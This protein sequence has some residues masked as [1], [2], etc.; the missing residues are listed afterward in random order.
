M[1]ST[2][3]NTYSTQIATTAYVQTELTDLI[4]GA[5]GTLDTLNE[6]AA[7]INDD[8]SYASTLTTALAT[9]LNLA[10][11]TMS[12]DINLPDNVKINMGG[13]NDFFAYHQSSTGHSF[14]ND[15]GPGEL[16]IV[17]NNAICIGAGA[18]HPL[19]TFNNAGEIIFDGT[20]STSGLYS[21][22]AGINVTGNIVVS[23]T[24]DGRDV[25]TDGTKLDSIA[26]SS[27][28]YS[29][30]ITAGNKHI[31]TGGSV[32]QILKNTASGTATWQADNNTTYTVGDGGLTQKNFTST[33]KTKL[34]G[35]E[36]GATA[37][38]T[39]AQILTAIKTVDGSGSGLDA[40][41]FDGSTSSQF[42]ENSGSWVGTHS[43]LTRVGGISNG[44][45][46]VWFGFNA[47]KGNVIVDGEFYA[48]EGLS[49]VWHTGNDS[50]IMQF[51]QSST[52][53]S[54]T[55]NGTMWFD[56]DDDILYQRQDG[57]WIQVSTEAAPA[58]AVFDV[59][60]TI[61]N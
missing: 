15:S 58:M 17:S 56:T 29:H 54:Q 27:N 53:P 5:P 57:A 34:D 38:Q 2:C 48:N 33:L 39:A 6:L 16:H 3:T 32:G 41:L 40:D 7:A 10:G 11:G 23:G 30:P 24:V 8:A 1:C 50:S 21:A 59:N 37:D 18:A 22:D 42:M 25:A 4:G 49:Q 46:E 13:S 36:T 43:S 52:A 35:I 61:V 12:G 51:F 44:G 60:G 31:P 45:G 55:R 26:T 14:L 20:L 47:G 19:A 28:N 9:K